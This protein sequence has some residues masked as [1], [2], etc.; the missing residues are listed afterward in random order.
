MSGVKYQIFIVVEGIDKTTATVIN[1]IRLCGDDTWFAF[2]VEFQ[3]LSYHKNLLELGPLKYAIS[4]LKSRGQY[5]NV[6][7]TLPTELERLYVDDDGNFIFQKSVTYIY[8]CV[9]C[10]S[11]CVFV[12]IPVL[13]FP[14]NQQLNE[15]SVCLAGVR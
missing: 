12:F 6:N 8:I 7:V 14:Y 5:R 3:K 13:D 9:I 15:T 1:R 2:P 11:V 4:G 10:M